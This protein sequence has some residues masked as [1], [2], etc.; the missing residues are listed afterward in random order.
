MT[1]KNKKI[2]QCRQSLRRF[3]F[4]ALVVRLSENVTMLSGYWPLNGFSF[5]F[6]PAQGDAVLLCPE[7]DR[8]EAT[9]GS[10][11]TVCCFASGRLTDGDAYENAGT[12]LQQAARQCGLPPQAVVGVDTGADAVSLPLCSG[13]VG[14][15]GDATL[16]MISSALETD[17]ICSAQGLIAELRSEK[18]E[19]AIQK[20]KTANRLAH[21]AVRYFAQ[22][23]QQPGC[24]EIDAAASTEAF[25]AQHAAD[26]GIRYAKAWAQVSSGPRTCQS[27]VSG[28][29]SSD[30]VLQKGDIVM[31]ELGLC[32]DGYWSDLTETVGVGGMTEKQARIAGIV[33]A[34]QEKAIAAVREGVTSGEVDRAARNVIEQAGLG[35]CFFH[36]TGH[37][38]GY[39]YHESVPILRPEGDTVL[40]S[41]MIHSVEPGIYLPDEFGIRLECNVLVQKD[42]GVVL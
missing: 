2:E 38:V 33:R 1:A 41:G 19:F 40:K 35:E 26:Y 23:V 36:N 6:V 12:L 9:Q 28:L 8:E 25:V 13:E 11:E 34:A 18:D 27:W 3:G 30:R 7:C 42:G 32:A 16:Q 20:I 39:C 14:V 29:V 17:R 37:G 5:V 15:P 24:R 21:A 22:V 31:L 10:V 4:D